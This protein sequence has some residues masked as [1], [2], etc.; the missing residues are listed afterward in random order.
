MVGRHISRKLGDKVGNKVNSNAGVDW[1]EKWGTMLGIGSRERLGVEKWIV[2][3]DYEFDTVSIRRNTLHINVGFSET[4]SYTFE[5]TWCIGN[6]VS[7]NNTCIQMY[8]CILRHLKAKVP[9]L[10]S[11]IIQDNTSCL[12]FMSIKRTKERKA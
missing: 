12:D 6:I 2:W 5:F 11:F 10:L 8:I 3:L 1:A 9:L 4:K 7:S